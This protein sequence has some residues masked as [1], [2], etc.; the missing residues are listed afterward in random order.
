MKDN[1]FVLGILWLALGVALIAAFAEIMTSLSHNEHM[2]IAASL[3]VLDGRMLYRD[4]SYLQTPYLPLVY[5]GLFQFL[6][7]KSYYLLTCKF[8]CL[9]SLVVSA[10][11]LYL[12]AKRVLQ[13]RVLAL[14]AVVLFLSNSIIVNAA[15]EVSN[16]ALPIALSV[17][18][19]YAFVVSIESDRLWWGGW[20]AGVLV[21]VAS[22]VKLTYAAGIIPFLIVMT[23]HGTVRHQKHIDWKRR[24]TRMLIP[25]ITGLVIGWI[26]MFFFM[27]DM[28]AFYFN[29]LGYHNLNT[30]WREMTGFIGQMSLRSKLDLIRVIAVRPDVLVV[31]LGIIPGFCSMIRRLQPGRVSRPRVSIAEALA[32]WTTLVFVPTAMMMTPSYPQYFAMPLGSLFVL[33]IYSLRSESFEETILLKR[34]LPAMV[35]LVL[36][37]RGPAM[38]KSIRALTDTGN[39][40]GIYV[41]DVSREIRQRVD[42]LADSNVRKVATLSPLYVQESNLAI[43]P[44]LATGPFLYRVGDLLTHEERSRFAAVSPSSLDEL[45][46]KEAPIAVLVGHEG[47]LDDSL[48]D[49]AVK[50][51]YR[52]VEL[53][54]RSRELFVKP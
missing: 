42:A 34:L 38:M 20:I 39:W 18:G 30:R 15:S 5:A 51:D 54:D 47:P 40:S 24:M 13:T 36:L 10:S 11:V 45:F 46:A 28:S 31:I 6:G 1:L 32:I 9:A 21:A 8:F 3:F 22:G 33:M 44:E 12:L 7:I 27:S 35:M 26:P 2:Y 43:Y 49:Y 16:Y 53:K 4:F 19:F 23:V 37:S 25:F 14:S 50:N 52:K 48:I 29:N 41:H 17:I